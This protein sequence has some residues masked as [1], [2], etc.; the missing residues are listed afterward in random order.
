MEKILNLARSKL[1]I[2]FRLAHLLQAR[3]SLQVFEILII[4]REFLGKSSQ[5]KVQGRLDR[6]ERKPDNEPVRRPCDDRVRSNDRNRL[7]GLYAAFLDT[8]RTRLE[9]SS[10]GGRLRGSDR[11]FQTGMTNSMEIF[12]W[13]K[14]GVSRF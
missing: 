13:Q 4:V 9:I 8:S 10:D 7:W 2:A 11:Q 12:R 5:T 1:K 14:R 6:R 3:R